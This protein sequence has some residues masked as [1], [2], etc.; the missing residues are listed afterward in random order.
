MGSGNKK[1][2][3]SAEILKKIFSVAVLLLLGAAGLV[4]GMLYIEVTDIA[5]FN[6]HKILVE[7]LL[8]LLVTICTAVSV[9]F[10]LYD[11]KFIYK[12]TAVLLG[13]FSAVLLVLYAVKASGLW[14]K[15]GSIEGLRSYVASYGRYT[16]PIFIAI[17]FLQVVVLPIPSMVT[18]GAGV[19]LFGPFYGA[20]Y[21][22]IGILSASILAFYIG[23]YLGYKVVSWIIGE[24]SLQKGLQLVKGK[25][26]IVL[27]FM[28]LFPFFPDDILC[29]VAGLS[30]MSV[31]FYLVMITATRIIGI[32][33]SSYSLG[34]KIIPFDTWWG[35][36]LWVCIFVIT[37][38]L[39]VIIYKNGENIEKK[40][41]GIFKRKKA[42]GKSDSA[43]RS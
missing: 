26:T 6:E 21:S 1:G 39:C 17:Q 35:I 43:H 18:I 9:V 23:R 34:G 29:F 30:T 11:K 20:L 42:N 36:V 41:R 4:F 5:F 33:L 38:V 22:L 37:C 40:I 14:D 2:R 10:G 15:I 24:K 28:F 25:D 7:T 3:D 27:T 32:V 16:V 8:T 19:A 13:T 31:K 12:I